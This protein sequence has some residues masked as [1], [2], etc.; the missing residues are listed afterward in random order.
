MNLFTLTK[1]IYQEQRANLRAHGETVHFP[2]RLTWS[3]SMSPFPFNAKTL[4]SLVDPLQSGI[5][6]KS[7]PEVASFSVALGECTEQWQLSWGDR[8]TGSQDEP[9][10]QL[11]GS[12]P[13]ISQTQLQSGSEER[14]P[15]RPW[16]GL[17]NTFK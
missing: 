9:A 3:S 8:R 4:P 6:I 14:E 15:F 16:K 1:V 7:S 11:L 10:S 12:L 17:R 2:S 5:E 13:Q